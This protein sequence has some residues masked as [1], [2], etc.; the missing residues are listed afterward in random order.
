MRRILAGWSRWAGGLGVW[1]LVLLLVACDPTPATPVLPTPIP[2]PTPPTGPRVADTTVLPYSEPI[3]DNM[4]AG[5]QQGDYAVF[6]H[7]FDPTM[8]GAVTEAAF[9]NEVAVITEK[10]G[11]YVS[12]QVDKVVQSIAAGTD[13][14]LYDVYYKAHFAKSDAIL[15]IA[16][17]AD[18][19]HQIAG[20]HITAP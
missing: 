20:F 15:R 7:D 18:P 6:V 12:R 10:Y 17:H 1:G 5:W 13:Q 19:P 9:T 3:V 4:M 16:I 14:P 11:A 8:R 2:T